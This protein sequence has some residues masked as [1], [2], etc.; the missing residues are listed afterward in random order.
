MRLLQSVQAAEEDP[1]PAEA[2]ADAALAGV[3]SMA[4]MHRRHSGPRSELGLLLSLTLLLPLPLPLAPAPAL[5]LV[6]AGAQTV[7][8]LEDP[9]ALQ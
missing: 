4:Q 9:M 6:L 5:V 7:L 1:I 2:E 3:H 8:L